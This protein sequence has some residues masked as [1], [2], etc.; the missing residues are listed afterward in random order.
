MRKHLER[1]ALHYA[2][3]NDSLERLERNRNRRQRVEKL[4]ALTVGFLVAV[5]AVGLTWIAF[6]TDQRLQPTGRSGA[7]PVGPTSGDLLYAK[8]GEGAEGWHLFT[9]D[10]TTGAEQEITRGVR[11]YGSDWSP[12]GSRVVYDS[13]SD[14]GASHIVVANADGSQ[15]TVIGAGSAP[16]WSPDGTQIAYAGDGGSIWVMNADGSHAHAITEGAASSDVTGENAVIDWGPAWSPDGHSIA[17]LRYAAHRSAPLP[18]GKGTTDVTLEQLRVWHDGNHPTDTMLTDAFAHIGE[19]DWSP[20]GSTIVFTGAP[21]LFHE[22]QTDGLTWP[23]VLLI[24]STGG[25]VTPITPDEQ[26]W[27][28]GATWSPDGEWIAYVD[29]NQSL[30]IMQPDGTHRRVLPI[31]PGADEIVGPSWGAA[32]QPTP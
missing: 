8:K 28:A 17:Y 11:D 24:P 19:I 31:D 22:Q 14:A 1:A 21:T 23:R 6:H 15:P 27:A 4:T 10:P 18:N 5:A 13:E 32:P 9:A 26:T 7:P 3:P 20:D 16:T 29:N 25:A 2:P 12:N 30:V